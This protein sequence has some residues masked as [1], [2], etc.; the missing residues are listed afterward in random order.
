MQVIYNSALCL[1][2]LYFYVASAHF[3]EHIQSV[4]MTRFKSL[5]GLP[6]AK[7]LIAAYIGRNPS[8]NYMQFLDSNANTKTYP[9]ELTRPQ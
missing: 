5:P 8:L 1:P 3:T 2:D 9:I 6:G 7:G 4:R